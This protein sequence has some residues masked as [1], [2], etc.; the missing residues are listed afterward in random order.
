VREL[1]DRRD[2]GEHFTLLDVREPFEFE[3]ARIEGASL[4]PLGELPERWQELD[5]EEEILVYCHSGM[6]SAQ[7]AEFL[8]SNGFTKVANVA[9]GIDAWSQEIDPS[10]PRY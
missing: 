3:I 9:G 7:A 6:R 2:S 5:R 8:R 1:R 10:V 4:I